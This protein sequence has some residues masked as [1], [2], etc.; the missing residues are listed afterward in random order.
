MTVAELAHGLDGVRVE[1]GGDTP[2]RHV[3]LDSRL[4]ETDDLFV[5]VRG[6]QYDAM[7]FAREVVARGAAGV[8]GPI[9]AE[10]PERGAWITAEDPRRVAGALAARAWNHPSRDL[11]VIGI[12]GTNGKTTTTFLLRAIL[13]H[14]GHATGVIGTVGAFLPGLTSAQDRTTPEAPELQERLRSAH[15]AG[16]EFVAMEVS[17]HALDLY[18][19]DGTEFAAAAF[20]NLSPEHLDWHGTM[21]DYAASK[22]RLFAELIAA[23]EGARGPRVAIGIDDPRAEEMAA[24]Q[25]A[26]RFGLAANADVRASAVRPTRSGVSF[27]LHLPGEEYDVELSL[28]GEHNVQN[29]LAAAALAWSLGAAGDAIAG[30][31][32]RA[33]APPGRFELVYSGTFDAWVDYAHTDDGVQRALEVARK[34]ATGRLLVV[35]GCGGDRDARKRPVIGG[36]LAR[37]AD[38]AYFTSDSPRTED[39]ASIVQDMLGGVEDRGKVRIELDRETALRRAAEAAEPGDVVLA[40]GKGH[41]TYQEIAG[42]KHPFDERALLRGFAAAA[43]ARRS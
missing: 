40:L 8:V 31:L 32:S 24:G 13:E 41:E 34:M 23:G 21:D 36:L 3:R 28:P 25:S 17:S 18:R 7:R 11:G 15:D 20:L 33:T 30:G 9:G 14:A 38:L 43:D 29:A 22:R 27:R 2:V 26:L 42:V 5:A 35:M 16:A 19:V 37:I 10:A 39:P 12:T 6:A 4:V 1:R